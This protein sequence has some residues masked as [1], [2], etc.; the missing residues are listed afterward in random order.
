V[1]ACLRFY[2]LGAVSVEGLL[3]V[4]ACVSLFWELFP[5]LQGFDAGILQLT[6]NNLFPLYGMDTGT[7]QF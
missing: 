3:M 7:Y 5:C 2:V 4:P 1:P 6:I